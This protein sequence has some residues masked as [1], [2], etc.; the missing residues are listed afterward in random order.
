MRIITIANQKGGVGKTTTAVTLGHGLAMRNK[1]LLL[2]DLDP[3]GQ[4]CTFLGLRQE[5]GLFDLLISKRPLSDVV[6]S[7]GINGNLRPNLSVLPGD[8][9]TATCQVVLAVEGFSLE[10]LAKTLKRTKFDYIVIDTAPSASL[11][12]ESA[13]WAADWLLIP[14]AVDY[15]ATEGLT[16]VIRTLKAI[17]EQGGKC[18]LLGVVPT[19]FDE[20]TRESK[21]TLSQLKEYMK[22]AVW[23]PIHRATVLR[24]C[25]SEG[26]TIFEKSPRCRAAQEYKT[27]TEKVLSYD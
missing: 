23:D 19:F 26:V 2:C 17:R 8:K 27:L 20:T 16:G 24:E 3:Q 9:R 10:Y 6:R 15:A 1:H 7:A 22:D 4:C 11:L 21:T 18:Q 25:T 13:I 14:C 12:L 5:S